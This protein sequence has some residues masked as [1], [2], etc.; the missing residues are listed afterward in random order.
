M[1]LASRLRS[2]ACWLLVLLISASAALANY[3]TSRNETMWREQLASILPPTLLAAS[4]A[5]P[6]LPSNATTVA[7]SPQPTGAPASSNGEFDETLSVDV[8]YWTANCSACR[9]FLHDAYAVVY[10]EAVENSVAVFPD[11]TAVEVWASCPYQYLPPLSFQANATAV[12]PIC[13]RPTPQLVVRPYVIDWVTAHV[14]NVV[15]SGVKLFE[16]ISP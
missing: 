15:S 2:S 13:V 9:I 12:P 10:I 14:R 5:A 1:Q 16:Y 11:R 6:V 3:T 8:L 7:P 4:T